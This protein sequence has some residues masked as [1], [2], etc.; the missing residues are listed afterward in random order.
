MPFV[1]VAEAAGSQISAELASSELSKIF[2]S[3]FTPSPA[4]SAEL[5]KFTFSEYLNSIKLWPS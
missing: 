3:G 5:P 2:L 1:V 4:V